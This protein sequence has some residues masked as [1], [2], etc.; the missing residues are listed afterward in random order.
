MGC[1]VIIHN[2]PTTRQSWDFR[3]CKGFNIGPAL[4]RY[5]C[6][7]VTDATTKAL[8]YS[9]TVEFIHDYL[10][11]TQVRESDRIVHALNF[12]SC[13]VKD[14]PASVYHNQLTAISNLRDLFCGW[15]PQHT[16]LTRAPTPHPP[17]LATLPTP[18]PLH[19]PPRVVTLLNYS[20][21]RNS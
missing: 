17:H 15:S 8:L 18:T 11:Q 21:D 3:G 5:R 7:H 2:K 16:H 10:T 1:P 14:A 4:N 6:F 19:P 12:L 13:A 9:D 20:E